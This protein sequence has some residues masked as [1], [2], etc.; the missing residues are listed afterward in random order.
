MLAWQSQLPGPLRGLWQRLLADGLACLPC[1]T[2]G[3]P[4]LLTSLLPGWLGGSL[5]LLL[6]PKTTLGQFDGRKVAH[7]II[8]TDLIK[9]AI[10]RD[11]VFR[12]VISTIAKLVYDLRFRVREHVRI[13]LENLDNLVGRELGILGKRLSGKDNAENN[14]RQQ[15]G[16]PHAA[17]H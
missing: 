12:D 6:R 16:E 10:I 15:A 4:R 3:L 13:F 7:T 17:T 9:K 11:F 1:L 5:V 2:L 8:G 14:Q